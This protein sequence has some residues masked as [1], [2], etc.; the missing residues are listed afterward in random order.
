MAGALAATFR[1]VPGG[2]G[3]G[4]LALAVNV[5]PT[6]LEGFGYGYGTVVTNE[7][8]ILE[9]SGG[10]PPYSVLWTFV[11][12]NVLVTPQHTTGES[13]NFQSG[14]M[15]AS[16]RAAVW[17]ATVSDSGGSTPVDSSPVSITLTSYLYAP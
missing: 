6:V 1:S 5:S 11:S 12:G 16:T 13:T 2:G 8:A 14:S 7:P 15:V 10:F 3:G 4:G 9:I 17:K